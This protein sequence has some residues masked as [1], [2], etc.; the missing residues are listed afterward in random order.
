[1]RLLK[2]NES[3]KIRISPKIK[4][5]MLAAFVF[6]LLAGGILMY[7]R[8]TSYAVYQLFDYSGSQAMFYLI[9][10]RKGG[11]IV[12]DGGTVENTDYARA[13]IAQFGNH[14]DAWIL[15]HPHPD[16]IGVFNEIYEHPDGITIDKIYSVDVDYDSYLERAQPYDEFEVF[17][18]FLELTG[19]DNRLTYLHDDDTV[20]ILGL[21]MEVFNAY[22]EKT[23]AYSKD[24]ANIGS[25]MFKLSG[26]EESIL[27]CSDVYGTEMCKLLVD[28]YRERLSC[29]YIQMGHH[30]NNSISEDFVKTAQPK[31][32]FF[33]AP[34]WLVDGEQ[35]DTKQNFKMV[36]SLDIEYY[37]YATAP[38][39]VVI[40]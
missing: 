7:R 35:Y 14:I 8:Y 37:Y 29:D 25:L 32:A 9:Q 5:V 31:T 26:R 36:Q 18:K 24:L 17:E 21:N 6:V 34:Q 19:G 16:H 2:R 11:L 10:P 28:K 1:M 33:D 30:G 3:D 38:N 12:I 39:K 13:V 40:H 22:S 27:F 20:E 15:T 23:L 4:I